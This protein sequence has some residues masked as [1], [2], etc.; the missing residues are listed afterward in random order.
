M[1]K[2]KLIKKENAEEQIKKKAIVNE[3]KALKSVLVFIGVFFVVLIITFFILK[4]SNNPKYGGLTFN[5]IQEGQLTFYHTSIPVLYNG[6]VKDYNIYLRNNPRYLKKEVPFNGE[7]DSIKI[8][9]VNIT[10]EFDCE[11]DQVIA[12]AN[13]VN[14]YGAIKKDIMKDENATCDELGRYMYISIQPGEETSVEQIG[15]NCYNINIKDCEILE[16]TE[17]FILELLSKYNSKVYS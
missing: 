7:I 10:K 2:K 17:R 1:R 15:P 4:S 8:T 16:G 14:V 6:E 5:I 13:L 9:A 3:N 11:G 12:I